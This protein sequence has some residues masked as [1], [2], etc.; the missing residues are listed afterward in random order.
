MTMAAIFSPVC[1]L[2]ADAQAIRS[3]PNPFALALANAERAQEPRYRFIYNDDAEIDGLS[4]FMRF[5]LYADDFDDSLQG[6]VYTSSETHYRGDPNANPPI[7]PFGWTGGDLP[8]GVARTQT[9]K[10]IIGGTGYFGR[11]G[12]YAAIY[13]NLRKHDPRFPTPEH[14]LS[15][16]KIG[17]V[18]NV[19]EMTQVTD[20]STLI[21]EALL[22]DDP[23]PLWLVTGG[24]TNTIAAALSSGGAAVS[25]Y[26]SMAANPQAHYRYS[27]R[28]HDSGSGSHLRQLYKGL[29][30]DVN[31][32]ALLFAA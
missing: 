17:N 18:D 7:P 13:Q 11:F 30:A 23:R 31:A 14:L 19:G 12:G 16:I 32:D 21:K 4:E 6:I 29:L 2:A 10:S 27:A 9:Y 8:A 24:G 5:L 25:T 22:A 20:G 3:G 15:L 1:G 28:V 26:A